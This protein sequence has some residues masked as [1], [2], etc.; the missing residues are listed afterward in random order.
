M[1]QL[2]ITNHIRLIELFAGIGSQA[3]ALRNIGAD[4]ESWITCEWWVQPNASYKAIHCSNDNKD[5]SSGM[6]KE[7]LAKWLFEKGISVDGKSPMT[8]KQI[9][10]KPEKW[11][12]DTFNNIMATK[13]IVNIQ[14]AKGEDLKITD[15]D[16]Y[17][18]ILTYSFPCQDLSI[19]GKMWGMDRENKTRS[20]MLWEVERL[21][22]E[23]GELPQVLLMENVPQVIGKKNIHNFEEWQ[24][25][26]EDK[27]YKNYVELLNAKDYG[28]AQNRNR[29][30][31]VSVLGDYTY[32]FPQ[33]QVLTK[34]MEDYLEDE[35]SESFFVDNAKTERLI[36]ELLESGK[37]DKT[38]SNTIRGGQRF[39]RSA[40]MG[41][42]KNGTGQ[43][44][45]NQVY[46]K[47]GLARCLDA[48]DYKHQIKVNT[49]K[50]S[51]LI[52]IKELNT[53][54]GRQTGRVYSTKGIAPTILQKD[55]K[56][57]KKILIKQCE[58]LRK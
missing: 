25:F 7:V 29:C 11:L 14:K 53:Q 20:G 41:F 49:M 57:P 26:L 37:L 51:G 52:E 16:K 54:E 10:K 35:V 36:A 22:K 56:D 9:Q 28:V 47:R 32:T 4:F 42:I 21:L 50:D 27:G 31:M 43:H 46:D 13:N 44:Q 33:K 38:V 24:Q 39:T 8:L 30:F 2:K 40:S 18:Y 5:Y 17:T 48:T 34:C 55:Y 45:S 1:Q 12:R 15:T 23:V 19:A 58:E 6:D 3:M